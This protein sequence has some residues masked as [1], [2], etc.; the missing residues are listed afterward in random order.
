MLSITDLSLLKITKVKD[1]AI[2]FDYDGR[3][4]LIHGT[5]E[6]GEGSG[7][8]FYERILDENGHYELK[9]IKSKWFEDEY[10]AYDYIK[11]QNGKTIV[12][13]NIDKEYFVYKLTKRGFATGIMEEKVK[14]E[15]KHI[16]K[17]E[18]Q[19]RKYEEKIRLLRSEISM[20]K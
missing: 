8:D 11:R 19:I 2:C 3:H 13:K 9:H 4:F 16:T 20:L 5:S 15:A 14:E 6:L 17:V 7:Q 12:Y 10:V 1:W 18:K